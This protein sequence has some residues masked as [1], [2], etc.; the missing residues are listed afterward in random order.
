MTSQMIGTLK[1]EIEELQ[2]GMENMS[3]YITDLN[4]YITEQSTP[5]EIPDRHEAQ[6]LVG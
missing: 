4:R 1:L 5:V 3:R 6:R 2:Q